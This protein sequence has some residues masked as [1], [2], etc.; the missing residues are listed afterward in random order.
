MTFFPP[1][2]QGANEKAGRA[3]GVGSAPEDMHGAKMLHPA[4][5]PG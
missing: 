3:R 5:G 4:V 1:G 2:E